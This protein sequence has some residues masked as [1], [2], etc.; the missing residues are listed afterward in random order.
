MF[1][2]VQY[3]HRQIFIEYRIMDVFLSNSLILSFK[4]GLY[5]TQ[6]DQ[7]KI[8]E[9]SGLF[10]NR[11]VLCFQRT[12]IDFQAWYFFICLMELFMLSCFLLFLPYP[13]LDH[14]H[15]IYQEILIRVFWFN[16]CLKTL[17]FVSTDSSRNVI[18]LFFYQ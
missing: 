13:L 12:Y 1:I 2:Q 9:L 16:N 11:L 4:F 14:C 17:V 5:C 6:K 7:A 10:F 15:P 3:I 18:F 8:L